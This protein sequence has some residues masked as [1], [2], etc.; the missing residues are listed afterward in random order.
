[1]DALASPVSLAFCA[2]AACGIAA[3]TLL[4]PSAPSGRRVASSRPDPLAEKGRECKL[5]LV[6]RNDLKMGKGKVAAQ[7]G[8]ATLGAVRDCEEAG[9]TRLLAKWERYGQAKVAVKCESEEELVAAYKAAKQ[10]GLPAHVV[11]DAGRTQIAPNTRTVLAVGPAPVEEV[12][13]VTG[14]FKLL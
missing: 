7:C 2:G 6:V 3:A 13:H 14:R 1:M 8:H 5:V 11:V 9:R 12:D 10:R 4:R